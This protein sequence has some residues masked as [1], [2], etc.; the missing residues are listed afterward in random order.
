MLVIVCPHCGPRN[1]SE[2]R[3]AGTS[4][5]RPAPISVTPQ[6][7]REYLYGQQN[8]AGWISESWYHT[9]G[10][11]RFFP[12]ERNTLTNETR[13]AEPGHGPR[14]ADTSVGDAT[15]S[16]QGGGA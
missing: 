5:Q 3:H 4:R 10:C 13:P 2:F 12:M 6:E 1:S 15:D 11:R 8:A 7:W 14:G 16:G 9:M